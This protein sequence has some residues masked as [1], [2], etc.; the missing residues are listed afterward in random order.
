MLV[1]ST[2]VH[3]VESVENYGQCM[4]QEFWIQQLHKCYALCTCS[5]PY[6]FYDTSVMHLMMHKCKLSSPPLLCTAGLSGKYQSRKYRAGNP[7]REIRDCPVNT[8]KYGGKCIILIKRVYM[9]LGY[10]S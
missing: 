10:Q 1:K 8:G 4:R 5:Y 3:P 9:R 2:P 7:V 6:T